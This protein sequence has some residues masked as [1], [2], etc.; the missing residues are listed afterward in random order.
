[1]RKKIILGIVILAAIVGAVYFNINYAV[2]EEH[3]GTKRIVSIDVTKIS[4]EKY[5]EYDACLKYTPSL[6][7]LTKLESL[8]IVAYEN[9]DL[10]YLSEMKNLKELVICHLD[11]YCEC[12][13][14]LP[15]LPNLKHLEVHG[16]PNGNWNTFVLNEDEYNFSNIDTLTLTIFDSV[17]LESLEYF[18]NLHTL[19]IYRPRDDAKEDLIKQSEELKEKGI[20]VEIK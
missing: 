3:Y 13:G 9:I 18:E 12:L 5:P 8:D 10:K 15:D 6:K 2:V 16:D 20:D 11:G 7:K 19:V 14:T 4:E 1:M 17:D